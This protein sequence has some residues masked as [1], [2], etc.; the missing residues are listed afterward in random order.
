MTP[1]IKP[2]AS[3]NNGEVN[4]RNLIFSLSEEISYPVDVHMNLRK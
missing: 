4:K 3:I 2:E 1:F